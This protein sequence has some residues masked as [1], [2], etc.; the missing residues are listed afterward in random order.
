M[1]QFVYRD[2]AALAIA[3]IASISMG[4]SYKNK[5]SCRY[6]NRDLRAGGGDLTVILILEIAIDS[7]EAGRGAQIGMGCQVCMEWW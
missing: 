3:I 6:F 5:L 7:T 4:E 1:C 2:F